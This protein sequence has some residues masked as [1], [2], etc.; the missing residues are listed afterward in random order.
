MRGNLMCASVMLE[1]DSYT[2]SYQDT[3]GMNDEMKSQIFLELI[4]F[5]II[6]SVI[7]RISDALNFVIFV[8]PLLQLFFVNQ[9]NP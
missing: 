7:L 9:T 8:I 5:F 4:K 3:E 1:S 6:I 2:L